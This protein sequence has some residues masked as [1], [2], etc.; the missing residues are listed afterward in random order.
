MNLYVL[1]CWHAGGEDESK[2]SPIAIW[3]ERWHPRGSMVHGEPPEASE[4]IR[5]C[6]IECVVA[7]KLR[8]GGGVRGEKVVCSPLTTSSYARVR[9]A[10]YDHNSNSTF[11]RSSSRS[12]P[13]IRT[14]NPSIGC[15]ETTKM[16]I[17]D[18]ICNTMHNVQYKGI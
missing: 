18:W 3:P 1:A 15:K 7:G 17:K 12:L 4:M 11:P 13:L 9:K 6:A 5:K 2:R 16:R 10:H 14:V 8:F